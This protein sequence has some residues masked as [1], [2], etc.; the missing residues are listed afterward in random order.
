MKYC[1]KCGNPMDDDMLFCQKCGTRAADPSTANSTVRVQENIQENKKDVVKFQSDMPRKGMKILAIICAVFAIIYALMSLSDPFIISMTGF[2]G[3]L[4]FMFFVLSKSPKDNPHLLGKQ[5][6]LNKSTFVII[7]VI[8]SFALC[9]IIGTQVEM[10]DSL[11]NSTD[12]TTDS[13]LQ[14]GESTLYDNANV[15]CDV[16]QFA[17]ITGEELV[18]LLGDP[19]SISNSTCV[20]EFEIPCICYDYNNNETL[21]EV[22]F[23]LVNNKVI[24]FTSYKDDY[25]YTGKESILENFG[26]EKGEN[27]TVIADTGVALRYRCPSDIVDDF[28]INLIDNDNFGF[29]QVTYEMMY[30][31]EWYLPLNISEQSN[32]QYWTQEAV[33]SLLKAP[34][35]ADF[36]NITEWAIGS[37]PFYVAVQSYVD[38]QN[39]FGAEVRSDFTF[40][41]AADTSEIIYAIFD[42]EVIADNGYVSTADL[43][44]QIAAGNIQE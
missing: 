14:Q 22:S 12:N 15:I 13:N 1:Y 35:S 33:K 19:D 29:L 32:Y 18:A 30:Y 16:E 44:S 31:E 10:D 23:E 41:Y 9:I 43:V 24:R 4:S 39:S 27:S 38:A 7:C 2:F 36:P 8:L 25:K 26:I 3:V 34:K 40:I 17:N 20:G 28:W 6:G 21:G 5:T 11:N 42:G 37:N